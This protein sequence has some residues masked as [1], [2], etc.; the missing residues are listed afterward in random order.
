[1]YLV[2][3]LASKVQR[4]PNA[5]GSSHH[6]QKSIEQYDHKDKKRGGIV[7]DITGSRAEGALECGSEAAAFPGMLGTA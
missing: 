6:S 7:K 1:L 2:P 3:S 4:P 5:K